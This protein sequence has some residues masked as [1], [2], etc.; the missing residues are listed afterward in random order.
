[1]IS[2]IKLYIT[3]KSSTKQEGDMQHKAS[4]SNIQLYEILGSLIDVWILSLGWG[5]VYFF[6]QE[7]LPKGSI[8]TSRKSLQVWTNMRKMVVGFR[9]DGGRRAKRM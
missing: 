4:A 1:M 9:D 8:S 5:N 7:L 3:L 6:G 2:R